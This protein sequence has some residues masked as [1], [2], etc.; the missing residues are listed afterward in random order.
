MTTAAPKRMMTAVV[1]D[2][3]GT[4]AAQLLR[5][6]QVE[7]PAITTSEVLVQVHAASVDHAN[8]CRSDRPPQK[9]EGP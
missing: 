1:Q 7:V 5:L 8:E 9:E 4:G 6:A 2:E 3:Y